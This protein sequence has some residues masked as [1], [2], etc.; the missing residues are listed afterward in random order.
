VSRFFAGHDRVVIVTDEQTRPGYLPSNASG[1]GIQETRID[2][3]IPRSVPL[4]MWNF[5]GYKHGAAPSGQGNRHTFGGLTDSA[6]RMVSLLEA[7]RDSAWPWEQSPL[8]SPQDS[9]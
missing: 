7:G 3:L 5:G 9:R 6:F 4:Y 8:N 1:W 2:D